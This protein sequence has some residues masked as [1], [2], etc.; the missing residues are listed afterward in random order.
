MKP[1]YYAV[2]NQFSVYL[3]HNGQQ[4]TRNDYAVKDGDLYVCIKNL[5]PRSTQYTQEDLSICND[6]TINIKYD[7]E[8]KIW[9]NF[10]IFHK[11]EVY[12]YTEY[13]V[14][15]ICNS[16]GAHIKKIWKLRIK[17]VKAKM[18]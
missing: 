1:L 4:L 9:K 5:R 8:Y 6:S 18:N 3:A 12:D 17:W 10:S 7:D 14:L 11:N 15:K 2:E 13:R 16:T